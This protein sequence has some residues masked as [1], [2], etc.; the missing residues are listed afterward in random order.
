MLV[1]RSVEFAGQFNLVT[2]IMPTSVAEIIQTIAN[3]FEKAELVFGHGTDNAVDEAAYLVFGVLH[4][5]H[6]RAQKEYARRVSAGDAER[7]DELATRRIEDR[8]PVAY[9][10]NEAW[11]AGLSFFVDERVLVPRSPLAEL[12]QG[13]FSP[14]LDDAY[15]SEILD[16]GTGSGCIAIALA[17]AFP[18]AHV[19]AVDLSAD[20]LA[21]ADINIVRHG[22]MNQVRLCRGSFFEPLDRRY[23]LIVSNPPYVD[24]DDMSELATEFLHEPQ[25]G[26]ASGDDGLDSVTMILH[27]APRF[28]NEG[29]ILVVEVGNSQPALQKLYPDIDFL[30]LE[31]THGGSGIFLLTFEQLH[32]HMNKFADAATRLEQSNVG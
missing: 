9:L 17:K 21:V 24:A 31:F 11:F 15:V 3:R 23:D 1:G 6:S 28:L 29:G 13:G 18:K 16:L 12:I 7:I 26:L 8:L 19:D 27:D 30:W 5:D 25:I 4:L 20:A 32:R 22:C 14:W 10:I 2:V